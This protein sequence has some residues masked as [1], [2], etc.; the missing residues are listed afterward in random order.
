[1]WTNAKTSYI[2]KQRK[3]ESICSPS[4]IYYIIKTQD[5]QRSRFSTHK[6]WFRFYEKGYATVQRQEIRNA[7]IWKFFSHTK[8]TRLHSPYLERERASRNRLELRQG[9]NVKQSS[10]RLEDHGNTAIL[11]GARRCGTCVRWLCTASRS[12][13]PSCQIRVGSWIPTCGICCRT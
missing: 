10:K 6:Q 5:N 9:K 4:R 1:M 12:N 13:P 7:H 11:T 2:K 3:Y 8:H